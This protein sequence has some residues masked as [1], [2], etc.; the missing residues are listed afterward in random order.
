MSRAA[1]QAPAS[2]G[3]GASAPAGAQADDHAAAARSTTRGMPLAAMA[4]LLGVVGEDRQLALDIGQPRDV[5]GALEAGVGDLVGG[6]DGAL[7]LGDQSPRRP[8]RRR[9]DA[10]A[11][12]T[13][14][15]ACAAPR[16]RARSA[17]ASS[18]GASAAS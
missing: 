3:A 15:H 6:G 12:R 9:R 1:S 4:Q 5:L 8:Q 17:L 7:V 2:A 11:S 16:A 18:T 14:S 13:A 10:S